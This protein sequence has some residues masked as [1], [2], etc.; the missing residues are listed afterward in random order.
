MSKRRASQ[1]HCDGL[2]FLFEF[3]KF[4]KF[5]EPHSNK[6]DEELAMHKN[7]VKSVA[8]LNISKLRDY[9]KL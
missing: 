1:G 2:E 6:V 4:L 3:K 5:V 8:D 7:M 9:Y